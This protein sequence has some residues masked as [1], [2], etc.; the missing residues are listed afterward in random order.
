MSGQ[1]PILG[2]I[3]GS[4]NL[5]AQLIEACEASGRRFFVIA[6]EGACDAELVSHVPHATVRIGAVGDALKYLRSAGVQ[7]VVMAGGVKRPS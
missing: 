1:Q 6:L 7:E 5:P 3:A 4:G 2:I